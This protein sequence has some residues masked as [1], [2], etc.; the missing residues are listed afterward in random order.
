MRSINRV[1]KQNP[2]IVTPQMHDNM[3]S[4]LHRPTA[5]EDESINLLIHLSKFTFNDHTSK[6][7]KK[8]FP[9]VIMECEILF[10]TAEFYRN[11]QNKVNILLNA[12]T[13]V[14]DVFIELCCS[15]GVFVSTFVNT[16]FR[17]CIGRHGDTRA[18]NKAAASSRGPGFVCRSGHRLL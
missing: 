14:S 11:T 18:E 3:Q 10:G 16:R 2:S 13:F 4:C 1:T 6:Y 12:L 15:K 5:P 7:N 9:I 17:S 8:F